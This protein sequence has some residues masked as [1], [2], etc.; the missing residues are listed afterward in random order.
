L[1]R[2][3]VL[4]AVAPLIDDDQIA[5]GVHIQPGGA[6]K[7]LGSDRNDLPQY[8]AVPWGNLEYPAA[9]IWPVAD[10]EYVLVAARTDRRRGEDQGHGNPRP[11]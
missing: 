5:R 6:V 3:E 9:T 2:R 8:R 10:I 7:L 4:G 1:S 11:E